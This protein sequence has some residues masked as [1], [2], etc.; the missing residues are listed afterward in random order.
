M[1]DRRYG[2]DEHNA[3]YER[4]REAERAA[5]VAWIRMNDPD[6]PV[7]DIER[8]EHLRGNSEHTPSENARPVPDVEYVSE[9]EVRQV[10]RRV[11]SEWKETLDLLAQDEGEQGGEVKR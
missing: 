3:D 8:G 10:A 9:S 1:S 7:I 4:G 5:I 11:A 6:W 2:P